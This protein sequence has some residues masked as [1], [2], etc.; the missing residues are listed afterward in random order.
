MCVCVCVCECVCVCVWKE[1]KSKSMKVPEVWKTRG[2][3]SR[4]LFIVEIIF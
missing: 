1:N 4:I 3:E 2:L